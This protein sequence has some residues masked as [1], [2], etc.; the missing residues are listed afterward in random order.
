MNRALIVDD[1]AQGLYYLRALLEGHGWTVETAQNGHEALT[2]ARQAPPDLVISD[3]LMPVMDGYTLLRHWKSDERLKRVPFAVYTATYTE[4]E[5]ERLAQR[6]GADAFIVKPMEPEQLLARLA[7]LRDQPCTPGTSPNEPLGEENERLELHSQVLIRKLEQKMLEL[8][9]ANRALRADIAVRSAAEA[10]VE[11]LTAEQRA[12]EAKLRQNEAIL[13]IAG[14]AARLGGWSVQLPD[15]RMIWS[16]EVCLIHEV[17][18]G[19]LPT[20]EQGI[21]FYAPEFRDIIRSKFEACTRD[22]TPFD[23][24]LQIITAKGRRLWVRA[25]GQAERGPDGEITHVQGAF[26][27][28]DERR[29]LA[30][31]LRQAQKMEAVGQLAGGV[32]HD[33]NNLLSVILSY[34]IFLQEQLHA[35]DPLL[36]DIEEIRR[37]GER[38]TELTRQLLAFSRQ[39]I[40]QPRVIDVGKVLAGIERMLGRMIGEDIEF[41]LLTSRS[42][43]KI[44]AD[45]TQIE[46]IV[47]NLVV[48]ARDAMPAGGN[49]TIEVS[50]ATLDAEYVAEHHDVRPGPYVMI[51]ITDSGCGM[52][53]ATR[54]RIFEPFFTTKDKSKGTGLGLSTVFGI[55]KQ[56]HGHIWVYSEPGQGTT[57]K[58]YLPRTDLAPERITAHPPAPTTLRGSETI[59][60]VEDE[61]Q[62]RV[63][64]HAILV[65]NGYTVLDAQ[66]GGEAFLICEQYAARIDLLITDVVMPRMSG[67]QLAERIAPLRPEMKVLYMSGYTENSI[68]HH[69]VLDPGIAFLQK[70]ITPN[71]LLKATRDVL[72]EA[73]P[74]EPTP[75]D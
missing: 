35:G 15:F 49:L 13:R 60:L 58:V 10:A 25:I 44:Y 52:D 73:P 37:A 46:Q 42:V 51:A 12:T 59:L 47:M 71:A 20:P 40:L 69:G 16:D 65:R 8:Q 14:R 18:A 39:Q 32:A 24:E 3:L 55:V 67:K 31:Q 50:D 11:T 43:G 23:L 74:P 53:A 1:D 38:A 34:S 41:R 26:Q 56:S 17:P 28:I 63:M 68:V 30:D 9:E 75:T 70:P 22:G 48:N 33:F 36:Q 62:V 27:D 7:E 64:S 4:A 61:E 19:T 6:F 29:K 2:K 5:D 57:F 66:N 45:P 72:G 21:Q 54:E